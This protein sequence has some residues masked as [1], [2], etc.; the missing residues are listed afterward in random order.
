MDWYGAK[1]GWNIAFKRYQEYFADV[2]MGWL[3]SFLQKY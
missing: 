2:A 3:D 1:E